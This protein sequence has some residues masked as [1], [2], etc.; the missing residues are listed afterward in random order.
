MYYITLNKGNIMSKTIN[1]IIKAGFI[2]VGLMGA[3]TLNAWH[4]EDCQMEHRGPVCLMNGK[5]P[6]GS[7]HDDWED[8]VDLEDANEAIQEMTRRQEARVQKRG[9]DSVPGRISSIS[10]CP[11]V[12]HMLDGTPVYHWST[13]GGSYVTEDGCN[14][15]KSA[16]RW[17]YS[18]G[19]AF[20]EE[21]GEVFDCDGNRLQ[22]VGALADGRLVY[23]APEH[24]RTDIIQYFTLGGGSKEEGFHVIHVTLI[25]DH[26]VYK[27]HSSESGDDIKGAHFDGCQWIDDNT[28]KIYTCEQE[29]PQEYHFRL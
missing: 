2:T 23:K 25:H 19:Y 22:S 16:D 7:R 11:V 12:G 10:I 27:F 20:V 26:F 5:K 3:V 1:T 6:D 18:I 9:E 8:E 24:Y 17:L 13:N 28:G 4:C 15:E 29:I 14:L 21:N